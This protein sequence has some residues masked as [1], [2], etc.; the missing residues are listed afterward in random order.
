MG[1]FESITSLTGQK[2]VI[3]LVT[4]SVGHVRWCAT[5]ILRSSAGS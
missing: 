1:N 5:R 2:Q 3:N 4:A